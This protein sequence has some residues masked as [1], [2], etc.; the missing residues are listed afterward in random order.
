LLLKSLPA[1]QRIAGVQADIV[2]DAAQQV[3]GAFDGPGDNDDKCKWLAFR[4]RGRAS[5]TPLGNEG[6]LAAD[7]FCYV[8]AAIQDVI[9][10]RCASDVT[11]QT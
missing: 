7:N 3:S 6:K 10:N 5:S 2:K 1:C 4:Q 9:A 11:P 8:K